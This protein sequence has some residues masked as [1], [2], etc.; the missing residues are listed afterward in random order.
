VLI[1]DDDVRL[2]LDL[3]ENA[4]LAVLRSDLDRHS[5][6]VLTEVGGPSGWIDRRPAELLLTLTATPPR[7]RLAT[8]PARLAST[9]Q[10][11]P[12]LSRWLDARLYGRADNILARLAE[13]PGLGTGWWFLRY[14]DPEPHLRLRIPLL[15]AD[16]FADAA[17]DLALWAAR[18]HDDGLLA[19]YTLVTYR[20]ETRYGTG[21]TLTAAEAV[22]AADSRAALQRLSG[23][24][25]ATTAAGMMTIAHAF[26]GDGSRWLLDHAPHRGGPRL[27]PAQLAHARH[28]YGDDGL[29]TA[30]ATYR[31]LAAADGLD[32]DLV[33]ADLLHLHHARMI[34]VDTAS[35][36]LCL[37]L[38]RAV[39]HTDLHRRS[40]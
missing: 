39:A 23:D 24:R 11:R 34:G 35:E 38:A 28:P 10:H 33:L 27:D 9:L 36:R 15:G 7:H 22:F 12:G 26:T 13:L 8:R 30:L 17:H 4:H 16:R 25:Q 21:P 18:L 3:D 1:G 19:D 37:R 5:S 14:P 32:T 29:A 2:R 6:A 31:T 40:S 20:P